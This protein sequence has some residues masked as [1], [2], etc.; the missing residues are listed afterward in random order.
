MEPDRQP[1]AVVAPA[2]RPAAR[3]TISAVIISCNEADV[4][5]SCLESIKGWVDEIVVVDMHSTD[6]TREIARRYTDRL[7]DHERL[8]Y[9][10]PA[11]N[12]A[13]AQATCDWILMLDPDEQV[14]PALALELLRV[15]ARDDVDV[16]DIPRQQIMFG[17][18][19]RSPGAADTTQTRFFRRGVL[20]WPPEVHGRPDISHLRR[21]E[22]PTRGPEFALLHDTWRSVP[23][24]LD[25]IVRYSPKDVEN[26]QAQGVRFSPKEMLRV[27]G[28]EFF[29]RMFFGR[30][31]EDGMA[32]LLM[33]L[34]FAFYKLNMYAE[35]WEA[36]GRPHTF[37]KRMAKWG[38][39]LR[40]PAITLYRISLKVL[41]RMH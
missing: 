1:A 29:S 18:T 4:I 25:K 30:A 35:L 16:V 26:L 19:T 24:V 28:H 21:V 5:E 10:D 13:F 17:V 39:R 3:S 2:A 27:A 33:S 37:D 31:Y 6:G 7:I 11:R 41:R 14:P 15:A 23:N 12:F 9:A 40:R 36:E 20:S 8:S 22:L 32:G 34:Y 38:K